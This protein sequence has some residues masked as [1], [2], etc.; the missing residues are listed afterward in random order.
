M[1]SYYVCL[2][3]VPYCDVSYDFRI[4]TTFGSSLP[5]VVCRKAHVVFTFSVF[6]CLRGV[7]YILCCV[8][9]FF[10]HR[11][12]YPMLLVSLDCA[13]LIAP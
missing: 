11:L 3:S 10:F 1:L 13:C 5:P 4:K 7:Q 2:R 9:V 8:F 6:V 12:V